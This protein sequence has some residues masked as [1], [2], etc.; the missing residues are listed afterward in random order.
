MTAIAD[1]M[2]KVAKEEGSIAPKDLDVARK[3]I[4][5]VRTITRTP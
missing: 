4:G 1:K 5:A 2:P 3:L